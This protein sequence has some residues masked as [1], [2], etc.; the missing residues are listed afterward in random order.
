MEAQA[1][2]AVY[3]ISVIIGGL[4]AGFFCGL[5]P[6][7][8]GL[9]RD[10]GSWAVGGFLVSIVAGVLLGVLAA[11]PAAFVFCVMIDRKSKGQSCFG[12]G[13]KRACS[14]VPAADDPAGGHAWRSLKLR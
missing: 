8:V 14:S 9:K 6:L 1:G 5:F 13:G 2:D 7:V 3:L 11:A 4:T 12:M 10:L